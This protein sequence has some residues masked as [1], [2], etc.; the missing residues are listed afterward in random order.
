MKVTKKVAYQIH[1][2]HLQNVVY[3]ALPVFS[4]TELQ[5]EQLCW[6]LHNEFKSRWPVCSI[7]PLPCRILFQGTCWIYLVLLTL[8]RSDFTFECSRPSRI[9]QWRESFKQNLLY[10][11]EIEMFHPPRM[12]LYCIEYVSHHC[13][14]ILF[15]Q[16]K[17]KVCTRTLQVLKYTKVSF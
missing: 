15:V 14:V 12:W 1:Q 13:V 11:I 4:I 6:R 7:Q 5:A 10:L 8:F 9:Y 3:I 17:W 16:G 2:D